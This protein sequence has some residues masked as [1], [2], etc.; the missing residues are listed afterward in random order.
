MAGGQ[1]PNGWRVGFPWLGGK[2]PMAGK[3]TFHWYT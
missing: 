3:V 2:F 1:V